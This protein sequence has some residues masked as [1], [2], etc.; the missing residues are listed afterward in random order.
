MQMIAL[1]P[2]VA[3][4]LTFSNQLDESKSITHGTPHNSCTA[5]SGV[6]G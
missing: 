6:A 3:Y 5:H 2:E 4:A 1:K